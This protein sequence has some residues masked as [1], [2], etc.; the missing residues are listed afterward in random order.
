MKVKDVISRSHT[1]PVPQYLYKWVNGPQFSKYLTAKQLPVK[2]GYSHYIEAEDKFI[3]GNSFTDQ[4]HIN[5]WTGDTLIRIDSHSIS[6]KIYPIPGNKTFLRTKGMT[7]PNYDPS[8]WIHESD[9]IDEYW[10]AGPLDL[11]SAQIISST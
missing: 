6:N 10:I 11:T 8:A 3:P 5:N 4:Q 1:A 9:E 7:S 2:R